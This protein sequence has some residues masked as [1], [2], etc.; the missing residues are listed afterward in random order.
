MDEN[1]K[2]KKYCPCVFLAECERKH[3]KGDIVTITT[4]Y[5]KENEHI[6]H[7]LVKEVNGLYYYSIT[8]ADGFNSQTRLLNKAEKRKEWAEK[9]KIKSDE[10]YEKSNENRDFLSLGEP[11]K[12]G[13]HSEKKHRRIIDNSWNNMGKSVEFNEKA[14]E[15][16]EKA[17]SYERRAKDIDLSMPES[18][19]Y[20]KEKLEKAKEKHQYLKDNPE[21]RSYG[22]EPAYATKDVKNL[23]DK[24]KIA[25]ILWK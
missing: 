7:N 16:N 10:Y 23:K 13:H 25:E 18:L 2:Y 1:I 14:K 6:I 21:A 9:S 3:E 15:H 8:R 12:V 19:E 24:V 20:F 11:I 4:K 22:M 17:E 5:G